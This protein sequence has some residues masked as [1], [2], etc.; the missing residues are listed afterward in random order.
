MVEPVGLHVG[1]ELALH[2]AGSR[3][4][5]GKL[6]HYLAAGGLARPDEPAG[7]QDVLRRAVARRRMVALPQ[8]L[9]RLGRHRRQRVRAAGV[10][11]ARLLARR[12]PAGKQ[13]HALVDDQRRAVEGTELARAGHGL[14]G[15][16]LLAAVTV[17][18]DDLLAVVEVHA[19]GVGGQ[20]HRH[21]LARRRPPHPA[22]V[23]LDGPDG[24]LDQ[25]PELGRVALGGLLARDHEQR[26]VVG[27]DLFGG[28]GLL[29]RS[30]R[31]ARR[32]VDGDQRAVQAQCDVHALAHRHQAPRQDGRTALEALE[33]IEPVVERALPQDRAVER[34]AGDELPLGRQEDRD[35]RAFV[36]DVEHPPAGG[37]D[38]AERRHVIVMA[39]PRRR[40]DPLHTLGR[41]DHRVV[42]HGVAR[43]V[44]HVMRPLVDLLRAGLDRFRPLA[45]ALDVRHAVGAQDAHDFGR[46]DVAEG[47]GDHE[48]DAVLDVGQGATDEAVDRHLAVEARFVDVLAS[49]GYV[50]RVGVQAVDKVAVIGSEGGGQFAV[51]AADV[52]DETAPD[53]GGGQDVARQV[54]AGARCEGGQDERGDDCQTQ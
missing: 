29:V 14:G 30:H 34:V 28:R 35:A 11:R 38:G 7:D 24:P 25:V 1:I 49:G 31:I 20:R 19:R 44:V 5:P 47:L 27:D 43:R 32:G 22:R 26:G 50:C 45:A 48:I 15:P 36:D 10:P 2:L 52:D 6:A 54:G 42:R 21:D 8:F 53:A 13:H 9:T 18:A 23:G 41:G 51:A 4:P 12:F 33:V 17:Q 3:V 37:D 16:Q 40:T 39:R 46:R